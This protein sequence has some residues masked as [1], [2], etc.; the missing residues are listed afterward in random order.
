MTLALLD[1][2]IKFLTESTWTYFILF[3]L[4]LGDAVLPVLPSEAAAIVCGIE[5]AQ[6]HL[7]L[8]WVVAA[9]AAG[10]FLG[11]NLSY[12]LGRWLGGPIQG[13]FFGGAKARRRLDWAKGFLADRGSYVLVIAR[14]IPGGRTATTFT[15]GLVR[16]PWARKFAPFIAL[17]AIL[18]SLY[19][20][21]LGYLGG[22]TFRD[23]PIYAFALAFGVALGITALIELG[24]KLRSRRA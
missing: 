5:A 20:V 4:C 14:F 12:A 21:L 10:A 9:A 8:G 3:A 2:L 13:R 16:L 11:D 18:W 24:R 7:S 22:R 19:G 23:K 15:S 6:G 1:G 17:A